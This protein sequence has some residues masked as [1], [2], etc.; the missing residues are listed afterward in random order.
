MNYPILALIIANIIWG[1]AIPIFKYS[2]VNVPTF[3]FLCTRFFG[4]AL[5]FFPAALVVHKAFPIKDLI[6]ICIGTLFGITFSIGLFFLGLQRA[7]SLNFSIIISI[8][9]ILLYFCAVLLLKELPH[10]R[11][12]VGNHIAFAGV[13][14]IILVPIIIDGTYNPGETL[15]N[16]LFL[17]A[18]ISNVIFVLYAKKYLAHINPYQLLFYMF[19]IAG[20]TL[21]PF[22]QLELQQWSWAQLDS[23]GMIGLLYGTFFSSALAYY[24]QHWAIIRT[25]AQ[26]IG[27]LT[28]IQPLVAI[29][30]AIPLL[31]EVPSIYFYIGSILIISGVVLAE[32]HIQ[33]KRKH[34]K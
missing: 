17:L 23:R 32:M 14:F 4:A 13:L 18:T 29:F 16:F 28:Y 3:I 11:V 9:P 19:A 27:V 25:D 10:W 20:L 12:I 22:A 7:P 5:I 30:I 31:H 34:L 24:L 15:G 21:L 2:L 6:R 8:S 26:Q 1:A 33:K